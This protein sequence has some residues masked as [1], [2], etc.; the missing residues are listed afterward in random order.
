MEKEIAI[1]IRQTNARIVQR[2]IG[3]L[4]KLKIPVGYSV[5]VQ[6]IRDAKSLAVAYNE[7]MKCS[8]AAYK[9][10]IDEAVSILNPHL[11]YFVVGGFGNYPNAGIIGWYGSE[12][13]IDGD[14]SKAVSWYGIY[15]HLETHGAVT[16]HRG[17]NPI[18]YQT[19]DVVDGAVVATHGDVEWDESVGDR[20]AIAAQCCKVKA[21]GRDVVVP[22]QNDCSVCQ[23]E[24]APLYMIPDNKRVEY[25]KER[26][27]FYESYKKIIQPLVSIIIPTYNQPEFVTAALESAL[28]QDYDNIEIVIGDD[29]TNKKTK[30]IMEEY[31]K[32]YANIKY[33]YHGGPLGSNGAR[34][35]RFVLNHCHGEYVNY[36]LHDDL[37]MPTKISKMMNYYKRDM[38]GTIGIVTSSRNVVDGNGKEKE[39]YMNPWLPDKDVIEEGETI[40]RRIIMYVCNYIGETSTVLLRKRDLKRLTKGTKDIEETYETNRFLGYVDTSMGDVSVWLEMA[41]KGKRCVFIREQLSSYRQH[42]GQNTCNLDILQGCMREWLVFAV[43]AWINGIFFRSADECRVT[44]IRWENLFIAM[45]DQLRGTGKELSEINSFLKD[46]A[47]LIE[48]KNYAEACLSIINHIKKHQPEGSII[49]PD[50]YV[51]LCERLNKELY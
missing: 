30:A 36:L 14:I 44:L 7:G 24:R 33:Y 21:T 15:C 3:Q 32:K 19:V 39:T 41:R 25:E 31:A 28:A 11:L 18:F 5:D 48:R 51:V 4:E 22:M 27:V 43:L 34:N 35:A 42:S 6:I 45:Q 50:N 26:R 40:G 8:G 49:I 16:V 13:P 9:L 47:W 10:Y 2:L 38:E 23:V 12:I 46:M 29:S 1:I 17:K 37:Y 20:F